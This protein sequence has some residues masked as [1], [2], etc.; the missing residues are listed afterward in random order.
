MITME[1][2]ELKKVWD[3]QNNEPLYGFNEAALHNR[4]ITKKKQ[5]M[6]ITNVS[7][8]L[9]ITVNAACGSFIFWLNYFSNRGNVFMYC[10]AA[11]MLLTALY[12][13][14]GRRRRIKADQQFNRSIYGDLA[15]A[16][17][18]ATY[19]V[20]FSQLMRWNILPMGIFIL[21]GFWDKGKSIW[22][23][24]AVIIFFIVTAY[25][26]G[27]EHKFYKRRKRELEIL[28]EKLGKEEE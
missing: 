13:F 28:R 5:G 17:S 20:R 8:F 3:A 23:T 11:W 22:V 1:F 7:E 15:H 18:V 14:V 10:L 21:L 9:G 26:S 16:I 6:H 2:D 19:Q 25:A 24:V 27:W 12:L 4:I